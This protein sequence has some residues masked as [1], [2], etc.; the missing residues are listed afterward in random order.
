MRELFQGPHS[1][2]YIN[3]KP[4]YLQLWPFCRNKFYVISILF[5][6]SEVQNICYAYKMRMCENC[7]L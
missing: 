5:S 2:R 3:S 6:T 7:T 4:L 1:G